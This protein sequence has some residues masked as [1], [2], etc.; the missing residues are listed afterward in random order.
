[1]HADELAAVDAER[2]RLPRCASTGRWPLALDE[3]LARRAGLAAAG[4][5]VQVLD[6]W[7]MWDTAPGTA[8]G[9][10]RQRVIEVAG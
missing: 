6:I 5:P 1:M 9:D 7:H 3:D 8:T 2:A 4:K 10:T